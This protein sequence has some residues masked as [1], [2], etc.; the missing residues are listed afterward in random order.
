VRVPGE[1][2]NLRR[3]LRARQDCHARAVNAH[4]A[5]AF[6]QRAPRRVVADCAD[7]G[8]ARAQRGEIGRAVGRAAGHRLRPLVPQDEHR[9]LARDAADLPVHKLIRHQV[10]QHHD[11]PPRERTRQRLKHSG[12]KSREW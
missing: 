5:Q 10:A 9:R 2:A 4:L 7:K 1:Q 12:Q 6:E 8:G 11:P 3:G